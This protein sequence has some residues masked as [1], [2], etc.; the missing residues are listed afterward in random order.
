MKRVADF[1]DDIG[2]VQT[3][4][5]TAD[6]ITITA[7]Q[8]FTALADGM[9]IS[10]LA[11]SDN[12]T[13]ATLN[14]NAIGAKSIRK[15]GSTGD[16][17]LT[18]GEIQAGSVYVL[19]Y[20]SALNSASGGWQLLTTAQGTM[21][22][23]DASAV[24]ITGG[25]I[26]GI[27]SLT[28]TGGTITGITDLAVADGGTGAS[29]A[30]NARTNLG[31]V[32][33]TDVQAYD[34]NTYRGHISGLT[35]SNDATLPNTVLDIA[36]GVAA[37]SAS[38]YDLMALGSAYTKTTGAWAVGTGNGA[39]DTGTVASSTWY[40]VFLI[41]RSDT[42]VVDLLFSTSAT[43]PTMPTSYDRKRRIGAFKTDGSGNI[44]LFHQVGDDFY[45]DSPIQDYSTTATLAVTLRALSV[46]TGVEVEPK[47]QSFCQSAS[48]TGNYGGWSAGSANQTAQNIIFTY[49]GSPPRATHSEFMTDTSAQI[50]LGFTVGAGTITSATIVTMGWRDK[51]GKFD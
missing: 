23:Q 22:A 37:Q 35:L 3:A 14:V 48:G 40:H 4:G 5:G 13:A 43:S 2:G 29:T 10:F 7:K 49:N 1:I 17:A 33:G 34:A 30:A 36:A 27:T 32:I 25:T 15:I 45:W 46:P 51:R 24:A 31:V 41:Q 39:L 6:A 38:P 28:A 12:T 9:F 21:A 20:N 8:G 42:S 44:K 11:A 18:G 19:V 47:I 16:T 26:A 50:Q